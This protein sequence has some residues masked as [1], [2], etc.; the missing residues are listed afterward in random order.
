MPDSVSVYQPH[1]DKDLI[2]HHPLSH[3]DSA[4]LLLSVCSSVGK[5]LISLRMAAEL[6]GD[7]PSRAPQREILFHLSRQYR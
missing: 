1:V 4:E 6:K 2:S 3:I 7:P 5:A